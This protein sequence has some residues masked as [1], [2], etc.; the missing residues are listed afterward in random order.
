MKKK[1]TV[2]YLF[3]LSYQI[4]IIILPLI[5]TPYVSRILGPKGIGIYSYTTSITSYFILFGCI[6]L[7]L[8]G[9]R[10]IAYNQN[11]KEKRS[12][13]F[14]E[15][16]I[17]KVCVMT[18]SIFAYLLTIETMNHYKFIFYIQIIDLI[19]NMIDITY[20]YQGIEE[21]KKI[22]IRNI[23]VKFV[24]I[25]CIFAFVKTEQDLP[26][27]AFIYS[28]SLLLGNLSMWITINKY[29]SKVPFRIL[30]L[31]KHIKPTLI[32]FFPQIAISI[33][34]VLDRMMIGL[35]TNN[36]AQIGY[37]EQAQKI[38]KLSLTIVTSLSTI[39][40]PRIAHLFINNDRSKIKTY[41]ETSLRY[42]FAI[43]FPIMFGLIGIAPNLIPWFLGNQFMESVN[44]L[45]ITSPIVVLIGISNIIGFQYLI[46]TQRQKVYTLST[47][48]GSLINLILNF[49]LI[50]YMFSA[51]AAIASVAAE[52]GVDVFQLYCIR[53]EFHILSIFKQSRNY[54]IS[55]IVM[56]IVIYLMGKCLSPTMGISIL[57]IM[58]G[59]LF[60]G[61]MLILLKDELIQSIFDRIFRKKKS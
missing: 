11:D 12:K 23:L 9:Q 31:K 22:V 35:L 17:I 52:L 39:M 6:G 8:Y 44:I 15:L 14:Y 56:F 49:I 7:N 10:E 20:F 36:T 61:I 50:P 51:G 19:A 55:S 25:I 30:E 42:T 48:I 57:L 1:L 60:Y 24:G 47:V 33:Y 53:K 38:V 37:Y 45:I 4:L 34:T 46:P 40:M 32:M 3:N 59:T 26:L 54:F 27:Y 29:I 58:I 16:L 5:T 2:N 13:T 21:F 41:T 28:A 43:S 18:I